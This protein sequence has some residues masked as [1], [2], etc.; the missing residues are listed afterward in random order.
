MHTTPLP[1]G[2]L[3]A[4]RATNANSFVPRKPT[5]SF[6]KTKAA[7][8]KVLADNEDVRQLDESTRAMYP[9]MHQSVQNTAWE[10]MMYY[11]KNWGKSTASGYE[12]RITYSYLRRA[13]NES[14]C[15]A[16][17]KNHVKKLLNMYRSPFVA[18]FR[19]GLG[20]D[21]GNTPCIVLSMKPEAF[22]FDDPRHN[23]AV[24]MGEQ[25]AARAATAARATQAANAALGGAILSAQ[26]NAAQ[27][28][29][30][31]MELPKSVGDLIFSAFG[32][33]PKTGNS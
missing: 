6:A 1:L 18:K 9:R 12:V 27:A 31:R 11:M 33:P 23:Q 14:C 15:I 32:N 22:V 28:A 13:L 2:L 8:A 3:M 26:D 5:F 24:A 20:A 25:D 10:L 30:K 21:A 16:T 4:M 7:L 29:K 17:L 19:G